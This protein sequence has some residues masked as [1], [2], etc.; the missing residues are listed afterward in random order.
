M[1]DKPT[2]LK[3]NM[4]DL[5]HVKRRISKTLADPNVSGADIARAGTER[6][7]IEQR[8]TQLER[9]HHKRCVGVP[10]LICRTCGKRKPIDDSPFGFGIRSNGRP[11][12]ACKSCMRKDAATYHAN[13]PQLGRDRAMVHQQKRP[14]KFGLSDEMKFLL[15]TA[16]GD[17]C[18][19]CGSDLAGSGELEH[20]IPI[21]RG[22]ADSEW[23]LVWA[24]RACNRGKGR[25]LPEEFRKVMTARG[26]TIRVG[27][28]YKPRKDML[29]LVLTATR[30]DSPNHD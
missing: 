14:L 17:C 19:Y 12:T 2:V 26:K 18:A 24:C 21:E 15:R 20:W 29:E 5:S 3:M 8:E 10:F 27:G 16:Q 9:V 25:K 11:K 4:D 28:F 13:D 6:A 22:G 23:N 7:W 30:H 1:L